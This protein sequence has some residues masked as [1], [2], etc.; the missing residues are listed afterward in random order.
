MGTQQ[1]R[2]HSKDLKVELRTFV[3]A[4]VHL[5]ADKQFREEAEQICR[6]FLIVR[7]EIR[8]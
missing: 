8:G 2:E 5:K 7:A 4:K 1:I 6:E 3:Q